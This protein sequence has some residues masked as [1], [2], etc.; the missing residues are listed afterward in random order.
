MKC[1]LTSDRSDWTKI[2]PSSTKLSKQNETRHYLMSSEPRP[3][4]SSTKLKVI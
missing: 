4:P 3:G 2:H 1:C